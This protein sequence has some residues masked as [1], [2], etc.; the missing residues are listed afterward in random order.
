MGEL[1]LL[2]VVG[3]GVEVRGACLNLRGRGKEEFGLGVDEA[4]DQP[5]AG[6]A[7]VLRPLASYPSHRNLT[8][9]PRNAKRL[10]IT[11]VSSNIRRVET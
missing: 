10:T 1:D 8:A 3:D 5:R 6:D 4:Y 7:I 2:H 9:G 11:T